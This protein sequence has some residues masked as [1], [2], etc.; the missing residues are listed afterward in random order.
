M[1]RR[2][3]GRI[4]SVHEKLTDMSFAMSFETRGLTERLVADIAGEGLF[5]GMG[6]FVD[7]EIG[8][9]REVPTALIALERTRSSVHSSVYLQILNGTKSSRTRLAS[10]NWWKHVYVCEI[11]QGGENYSVNVVGRC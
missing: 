9:T 5:L 1:D 7:H 4:S 2:T 11:I 10:G 8:F 6:S 3:S